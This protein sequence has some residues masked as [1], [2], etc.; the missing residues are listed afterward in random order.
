MELTIL[1]TSLVDPLRSSDESYNDWERQ[2]NGRTI[3][4]TRVNLKERHSEM[5]LKGDTTRGLDDTSS[6]EAP[7]KIEPTSDKV[8]IAGADDNF[9]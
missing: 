7:R 5:E 6:H 4:L 8:S 3:A 2:R 9:W 1:E